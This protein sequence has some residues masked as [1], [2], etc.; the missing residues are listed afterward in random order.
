MRITER[1]IERGELYHSRFHRPNRFIFRIVRNVRGAMKEIIH[2]VTGESFHNGAS[3]GSGNRFTFSSR[4]SE[5]SMGMGAVTS[6]SHRSPDIPDQRSG[7]ANPYGCVQGLSG[8][9]HQFLRVFIHVAHGVGFVQV[10]MQAFFFKFYPGETVSA[11]FITE[12]S[13]QMFLT[14]SIERN[15]CRK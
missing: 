6:G 12:C 2:T 9:T 3:V 13:E 11:C 7:F 1:Y 14:I 4:F 8:D 15:V 10:R 5:R